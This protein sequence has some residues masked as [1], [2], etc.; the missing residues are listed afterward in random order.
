MKRAVL[1]ELDSLALDDVIIASNSS[2]YTCSEIL[3]TLKLKNE[4]RFLSAH[5]C[6]FLYSSVGYR[7]CH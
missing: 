7:P 1:A 3:G 6:E 5:S 2:S 4:R